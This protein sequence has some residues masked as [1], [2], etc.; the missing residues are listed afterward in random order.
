MRE[1]E[2]LRHQLG[3]R[4]VEGLNQGTARRFQ[5]LEVARPRQ[6]LRLAHRLPADAFEDRLAQQ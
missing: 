3:R 4:L 1:P 2:L 6:E 5:G